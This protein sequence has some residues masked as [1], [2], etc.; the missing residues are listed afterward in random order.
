MEYDWQAIADAARRHGL[1]SYRPGDIATVYGVTRALEHLP[2][3]SGA[4]DQVREFLVES[5][6][7]RALANE[8]PTSIYLTFFGGDQGAEYLKV[9]VSGSLKGR[10]SSIRTSNP[11]AQ[12]WTWAGA[13]PSRREAYR[14]EREILAHLSEARL[15]GEWV[16]ARCGSIDV[17]QMMVDSISEFVASLVGPGAVTFLRVEA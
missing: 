6:R 10:M 9:G 7:S 16:R 17:A 14:L 12:L 8:S 1:N 4:L 3:G 13:A 15:S 5:L 2:L 11:M